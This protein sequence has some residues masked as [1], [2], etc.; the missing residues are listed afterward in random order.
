MRVTAQL[1]DAT[2]G[3]HVWSERWDRPVEDV[4]AVQSEVADAVATRLGE[5][6]LI[7]G[8]ERAAAK[9]KRPTDLTAYDLTLLGIEQKQRLTKESMEEAVRLYK[10]S[11]AIDPNF[12]GAWLQLAWA[13]GD[14]WALMDD[15]PELWRLRDEA[16][17][18]AAE[19][20]PENAEARMMLGIVYADQGDLVRAKAEFDRALRLNPG[21]AYLLS[22]YTRWATAFGEPRKVLKPPSER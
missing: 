20:D 11:L 16:A 22:I 3:T 4:F 7:A 15:M 1:I 12:A 18:R 17:K 10:Q 2:T 14:L 9:R 8:A 5:N 19:L 13:Y 21:S 6:G